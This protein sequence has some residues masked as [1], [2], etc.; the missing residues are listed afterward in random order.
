MVHNGYQEAVDDVNSGKT[1]LEG[2]EGHKVGNHTRK[3]NY[4][5]MNTDLK[6]ES[7]TE[8][9]GKPASLTALHEKITDI[10]TPIKQGIDHIYQNATPP[11]K[12]VI[13]ESKYGSS[14]LNPK[15]K[16][17]PQMSD[18][19]I[20]G[21]NRLDKIVGEDIARDI[22]KALD[23]GQVDRVLSKIDTNGNVTT[24][25]LDNLGNVIDNWK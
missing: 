21:N 19:W 6:M 8:I 7:I 20:K 11:P 1:P 9:D 18:D 10:D 4:G 17:G 12:Y 25:K 14:T 24:Y 23:R 5:E 13:V 16:D 2:Y 15:T 3:S 22:E